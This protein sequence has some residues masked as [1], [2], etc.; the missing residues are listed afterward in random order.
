MAVAVFNYQDWILDYPELA[1]KVT[2]AQ[3]RR[4]F[5][6]AGTRY[7]NNTDWSVVQDIPTRTDLLYLLVAHMAA[8]GIA[9]ADPSFFGAGRVSSATQGS[10]SVSLDVGAMSGTEAWYAQTTYGWAYWAATAPYRT[11]Q[12]VPDPGRYLGVPGQPF[13]WNGL[14]FRS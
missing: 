8:L 4:L 9:R 3:G 13:G 10:V 2:E 14:E 1:A 5:A 7:L 12:Y 6:Q 11:M